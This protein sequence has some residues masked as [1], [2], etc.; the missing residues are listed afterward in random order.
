MSKEGWGWWLRS[1]GQILKNGFGR[2]EVVD[3]EEGKGT[4]VRS[5]G[6]WIEH[7]LGPPGWLGALWFSGC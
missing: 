1:D 7:P 2:R 3:A 5:L 4:C 6:G